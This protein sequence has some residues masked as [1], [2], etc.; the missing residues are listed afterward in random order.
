[1]CRAWADVEWVLKNWN[2]L[3][4]VEIPV[5]DDVI[6][7]QERDALFLVHSLSA[8]QPASGACDIGIVNSG[9]VVTYQTITPIQYA[10]QNPRLRIDMTV[11]DH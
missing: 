3:L 9:G 7:A 5:T 8:F 11:L 2:V 6:E 1:M 10:F 4:L